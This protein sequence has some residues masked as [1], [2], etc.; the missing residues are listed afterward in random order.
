MPR[1]IIDDP[2]DDIAEELQDS[3]DIN[4]EE[5]VEEKEFTIEDQAKL[6]ENDYSR[7]VPSYRKIAHAL[8]F[9]EK[10]EK[11]AKQFPAPSK[12]SVNGITWRP[13][14]NMYEE[15][16]NGSTVIRA[17]TPNGTEMISRCSVQIMTNVNKQ[18]FARHTLWTFSPD[19][20]NKERPK[21]KRKGLWAVDAASKSAKYE[22]KRQEW[23]VK[24]QDIPKRD[25]IRFR[26]PDQKTV[27]GRSAW[28]ECTNFYKTYN[29]SL[30]PEGIAIC[31]RNINAKEHYSGGSTISQWRWEWLH[32][33]AWSLSSMD[34]DPQVVDNLAAAPK[35]VNN[36]MMIVERTAKWHALH[37]PKATVVGKFEFKVVPNSDIMHSGYIKFSITEDDVT[38]DLNLDLD[39]WDIQ[40]IMPN[41]TDIMQTTLVTNGLLLNRKS[42]PIQKLSPSKPIHVQESL[43]TAFKSLDKEFQSSLKIKERLRNS[44]G[45]SPTKLAIRAF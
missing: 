39:P 45:N 8:I 17:S 14:T 6:S 19:L 29:G 11:F 2:M 22:F 28:N 43:H 10:G 21:L 25:T 16:Q 38:V 7:F 4:Y 12:Q 33:K 36:L 44:G 23:Q 26:V 15:N 31:L 35:W 37:R 13:I 9:S 41:A 42:L 30:S 18:K 3:I 27:M 1:K 24:P 20:K 40:P 32:G 34:D 5:E